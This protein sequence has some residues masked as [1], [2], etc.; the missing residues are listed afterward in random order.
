MSQDD[1]P[2]SRPAAGQKPYFACFGFTARSVSRPLDSVT[3]PTLDPT[4]DL[5]PAKP[6]ALP[7]W[8]QVV[9]G[10]LLTL[11]LLPCLAGSLMMLL[12]PNQSAPVLA[13]AAGAVMVLLSLWLFGLCFRLVS[14]R[15]VS[16][17][18]MAPRTLRAVA[19]L[20]LFLPL[21]GLFTGY[22]AAHTETALMQSAAYVSVFFGLR[23]LAQR[24]AAQRAHDENGSRHSTPEGY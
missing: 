22:F 17:G 21:G 23:S 10:A 7:R 6:N 13:P 19:W 9:V 18:L 24:R 15:R 4:P 20:F 16:G 14:G 11:I 2:R 1:R 12:I 8:V 5:P 3:A